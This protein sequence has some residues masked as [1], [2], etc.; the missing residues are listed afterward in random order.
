MSQRIAYPVSEYSNLA[1]SHACNPLRISIPSLPRLRPRPCPLHPQL[2]G[3]SP[4]LPA[5]LVALVLITDYTTFVIVWS[6]GL[7]SCTVD[8]LAGADP[9]HRQLL[10]LL[11]LPLPFNG[12]RP[13]TAQPIPNPPYCYREQQRLSTVLARYTK[14]PSLL[15]GWQSFS[16]QLRSLLEPTFIAYPL[17]LIP[18]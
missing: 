1:H 5:S 18:L 10:V 2:L 14:L 15:S 13:P 3:L 16:K 11:P 4:H 6:P 17:I 7:S 8:P 12:H 9:D